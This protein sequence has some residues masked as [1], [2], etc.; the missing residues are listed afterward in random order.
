MISLDTVRALSLDMIMLL[1]SIN[2]QTIIPNNVWCLNLSHIMSMHFVSKYPQYNMPTFCYLLI[3]AEYET[4]LESKS[5]AT[6]LNDST[7]S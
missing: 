2:Q 1:N 3:R 5:D 4:T 6:I 7:R